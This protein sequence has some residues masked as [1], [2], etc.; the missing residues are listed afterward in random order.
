MEDLNIIIRGNG[1]NKN[2]SV[3]FNL[4]RSSLKG[5]ALCI[6]NN[7]AVEQEEE[8]RDTHIK[9]LC[10]ITGQVFPNDNP[11]L[12]Q[13]TYMCNHVFLHLSKRQVSEFCARWDKINNWLDEFLPFQPNQCFV[14]EQT[15]DIL[16]TIIP[17]RWQSYLQHNK[18]DIIRC[19]VRDFF[20]CWSIFKLQINLIPL[21]KPKDQSK[22]NKDESNKLSEKPN[23]KKRKAKLKKNDSETMVPS[24]KALHVTWI[25]WLPY[26]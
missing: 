6:F 20:K 23:D 25:Q 8:M 17:K 22:T 3:H 9:C 16:Y 7:K 26:D 21:L 5:E 2:G 19:S 14:D 15:K 24:Q 4:T 18:F 13:K 11:L 10:A 12:K 1:L